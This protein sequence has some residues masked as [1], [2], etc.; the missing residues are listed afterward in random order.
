ML[1][2]GLKFFN[3]YDF[4]SV[5]FHQRNSVKFAYFAILSLLF[6][7]AQLQITVALLVE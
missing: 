2:L 3:T 4:F 6:K 1:R 7:K 5:K